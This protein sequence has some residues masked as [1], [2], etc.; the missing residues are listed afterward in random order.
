[1]STVFVQRHYE[2][3]LPGLASR[4]RTALNLELEESAREHQQAL[5]ASPPPLTD[6]QFRKFLNKVSLFFCLI[7]CL[8]L[9]VS[10]ETFRLGLFQKFVRYGIVD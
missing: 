5:P 7:F 8:L 2:Q 9:L 10:F 4:V 6:D 3:T 1:M